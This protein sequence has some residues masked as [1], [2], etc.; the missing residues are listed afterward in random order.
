MKTAKVKFFN[1]VKGFGFIKPDDGSEDLFYHISEVEDQEILEENDVVT[2]EIGKGKK[3][4]C[5]KNVKRV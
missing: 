5:A 2:F 1:S 4:P 3:G